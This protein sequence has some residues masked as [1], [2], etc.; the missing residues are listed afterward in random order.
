MRTKFSLS[1]VDEVEQFRAIC[2]LLERRPHQ[3][4][5]DLVRDGISQLM[6]EPEFADTVSNLVAIS[7]NNQSKKDIEELNAIWEVST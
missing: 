6:A 7:R 4:V 3:L 5:D 1:G 2:Y